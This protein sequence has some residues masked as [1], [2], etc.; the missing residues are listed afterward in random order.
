M[1]Y[2]LK[3]PGLRTWITDPR[4]LWP[5]RQDFQRHIMKRP[6]TWDTIG[7]VNKVRRVSDAAAARAWIN[8]SKAITRQWARRNANMRTGGF[9]TIENKYVDYALSANAITTAWTT[10]EQD[11][12]TTL[13]LNAVSQG[14]GQS[15]RIGLH[16]D[17][18]AIHIK[19][20]LQQAATESITTPPSDVLVRMAL[21]LDTQTNAAQLAA[22]QVFDPAANNDID[23]FRNLEYTKRFRVLKDKLFRIPVAS[24]AQN[25][26]AAN[27]FSNG[28]VRIPFKF[29]YSFK[30][31]LRVRYS[32]TATPPTVA[33]ITDNSLHLVAVYSSAYSEAP[34]ISY[35]SRVR[36]TG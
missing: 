21:V 32:D 5:T 30:R 13:C 14:A 27:L 26:G 22:E 33:E 28:A 17:I 12:A 9:A 29:N 36:F 1:N 8:K 2:W 20:F 31:P 11:P 3:N 23:S 16:Q 7:P 18:N 6:R 35:D 15:Q 19:G 25:E 10:G 24:A 4:D 34:T